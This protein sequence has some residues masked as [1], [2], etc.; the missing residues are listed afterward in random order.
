[1]HRRRAV[2]ALVG[3]LAFGAVTRPACSRAG[4]WFDAS[5]AYDQD[6]CF[7]VEDGYARTDW[8]GVLGGATPPRARAWNTISPTS[9]A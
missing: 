7:R 6:T 1:M 2:A 3:V 8:N 4:A 5:P 9:P